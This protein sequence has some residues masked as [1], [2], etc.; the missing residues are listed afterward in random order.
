[1]AGGSDQRTDY[2]YDGD[3]FRI[4]P[5]YFIPSG[6]RSPPAI[7]TP[8]CDAVQGDQRLNVAADRG[9]EGVLHPLAIP[10]GH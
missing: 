3:G 4:L 10:G 8:H 5:G 1:M 2:A 9:V 6:Q 7:T